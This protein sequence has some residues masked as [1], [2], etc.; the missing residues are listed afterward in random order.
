MSRYLDFINQ[1][2]TAVQSSKRDI[3]EIELIA[4]SKTKSVQEIEK[5]INENHFSF[6]ENKLQEIEDKW[7]TLKD[8]YPK[9]RLHYLGAIQS[10][11]INSIHKYCDVIHSLDRFKTVNKFNELEAQSNIKREYFIQINIGNEQQKSGVLFSDADQFIGECLS[12]YQINIIGLMCLPP[13]EEDPIIHFKNLRALAEKFNL[14]S[15]SMGMSGDYEQA[16][17]AGSTHIRIGTNIF[18]KRI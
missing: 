1:F 4:V 9:V 11:K 15:L 18:G 8:A 14:K 13:V 17:N 5:V 12:N 16:I 3:S 6:G 7:V 2:Q 10:K